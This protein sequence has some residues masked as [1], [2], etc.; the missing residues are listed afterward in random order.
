MSQFKP[1]HLLRLNKHRWKVKVVGE[2][3]TGFMCYT[4][5]VTAKKTGIHMICNVPK[6]NLEKLND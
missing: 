3:V 4:H 6:E 5:P 2:Y 1:D